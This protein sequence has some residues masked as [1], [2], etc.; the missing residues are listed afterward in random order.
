VEALG[1]LD[2]TVWRLGAEGRPA[3]LLTIEIYNDA[4]DRAVASY[5][6]AALAN[7]QL[8]LTHAARKEL[9]WQTPAEA[10][11]LKPLADAPPPADTPTARL[12]Q[13]RRLARRFAVSE[14]F[15]DLSIECRLLAQPI[16]RYSSQDEA[17][18]D[19]ALFV[20][21][22]GT[23]PEV[24]LLLECGDTSWTYGL[25][26]LTSAEASVQLDGQEVA[27]FKAG[28]FRS[29]RQGDYLAHVHGIELK[30]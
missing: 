29:I 24:G 19:G 27:T 28:D 4:G 25:M 12:G 1:L 13:M 17:L 30:K 7:E 9:T 10:F 23:N 3:G 15:N 22:N 5:E 20:F 21:A 6:F 11:A 14:V 8:S 18:V 2:A 26:R 16:D